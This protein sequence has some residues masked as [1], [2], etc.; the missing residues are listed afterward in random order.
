MRIPHGKACKKCPTI[1]LSSASLHARKRYPLQYTFSVAV[2]VFVVKAFA[3][4]D[5]WSVSG[6][7]PLQSGPQRRGPT[8][9]VRGQYQVGL[10]AG[11]LCSCAAAT[12]TLQ[13]KPVENQLLRPPSNAD[14]Q[15]KCRLVQSSFSS[16]HVVLRLA[17]VSC[18]DS[19]LSCPHDTDTKLRASKSGAAIMDPST[20]ILRLPE[21][22]THNIWNLPFVFVTQPAS[23]PRQSTECCPNTNPKLTLRTSHISLNEVLDVSLGLVFGQPSVGCVQGS[24]W[25]PPT[26][27]GSLRTPHLKGRARVYIYIYIHTYSYILL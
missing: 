27:Q 25:S 24:G 16:G 26:C 17:S 3:T 9:K 22:R 19:L 12:W 2:W 5:V 1:Q 8:W 14:S 11:S 15:H 21:T 6:Y 23:F 10:W 7:T 20:T 13:T 4:L 18:W